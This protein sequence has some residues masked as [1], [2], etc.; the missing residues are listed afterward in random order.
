MAEK[1]HYRMD[2][3][4]RVEHYNLRTDVRTNMI[5]THVV[6]AASLGLEARWTE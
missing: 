2:R 6:S 4:I 5:Y 3:I 1:S